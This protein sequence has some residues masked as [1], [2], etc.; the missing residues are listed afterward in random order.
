MTTTTTTTTQ[1]LFFLQRY[2]IFIQSQK[3]YPKY[4]N[5]VRSKSSS[6]RRSCFVTTTTTRNSF[7][8]NNNHK[9]IKSKL[10]VPKYQPRMI[11]RIQIRK[12]LSATNDN[13]NDNNQNNRYQEDDDENY[14][15]SQEYM[16]YIISNNNNDNNNNN[17]N[18]NN[19][20]K[21]LIQNLFQD[22]FPSSSVPLSKNEL[23]EMKQIVDDNHSS[24]FIVP[25]NNNHNDDNNDSN[26]SKKPKYVPLPSPPPR[27][28]PPKSSLNITE[29]SSSQSLPITSPPPPPISKPEYNLQTTEKEVLQFTIHQIRSKIYKQNDNIQFNIHSPKQVSKVLF[30]VD[31]ESTSREV[32]EGLTGNLLPSRVVNSSCKDIK[33]MSRLILEFRRLNTKLRKIERDEKNKLNGSH[34]NHG[35]DMASAVSIASPQRKANLDSRSSNGD[36]SSKATKKKKNNKAKH[37]TFIPNELT[38]GHKY[39]Q[40]QNEQDNNIEPLVLIDAS[41]YIFRAYYSMPPIHRF[42][43]EPTGATLGFCNMLNRLIM[44]PS[45]LDQQ[46]DPDNKKL[47]PRIVLVFDSKDGTNFR[48]ELYP[49]YKANRKACPVDLIPQFDHVRDAADAYGILQLEAAGYEADDVI[50]TIATKA[51]EEGCFVN[52]LSGDKDLMQLV[53]REKAQEINDGVNDEGSSSYYY[54]PCIQLI[55]PMNMVRFDYNGVIDKWGV[56]PEQ[57]GDVLALAGD[58]SDNIPGVPGIGPK[59]AASLI[60]E[61]GTLDELIGNLD[62]VKQKGRREKLKENIELVSSHFCDGFKVSLLLYFRFDLNLCLPCIIKNL[63]T[64]QARLSRELVELERNVPLESMSIPTHFNSISD[65]RME[66]FDSERLLKF[67]DRM[68]FRDLKRRMQSRIEFAR[69]KPMQ[70]KSQS[71]NRNDAGVDATTQTNDAIV[72]DKLSSLSRYDS[73]LEGTSLSKNDK[74]STNSN[75][76]ISRFS[77]RKKVD[78]NYTNPPEPEEFTDVPF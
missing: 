2:P 7:M 51:L 54:Q 10:L 17:N 16:D 30:G 8:N 31:N 34:V 23:Q 56:Q 38:L 53:T 33:E 43:G 46:N 75:S 42:D 24:S 6:S 32:L 58:T 61:Y 36:N 65:F 9:S 29:S 21:M 78:Y 63:F 57:L 44:T 66:A 73:I 3:H 13:S 74:P 1:L 55:D 19:D 5:I 59:I 40:Q 15:Y 26:D 70:Y 28:N 25:S 27:A 69:K 64:N 77:M 37:S 18:N 35:G 12:L 67:Y 50:A 11:Q 14:K 48:K 49:E 62:S 71:S 60:E 20:S 39:Y 22:D 47:P 76:D 72:D 45:F 68:G 41:A 4:H 52:I